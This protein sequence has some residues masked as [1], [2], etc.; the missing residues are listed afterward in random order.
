M[1]SESQKM[2]KQID[3]LKSLSTQNDEF[4]RKLNIVCG[5]SIAPL[6]RVKIANHVDDVLD[7]E[8]SDKTDI[9]MVCGFWEGLIF[10]CSRR[11]RDGFPIAE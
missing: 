10:P 8:Q 6:S 4:Q 2:N 9:G 11:N 1:F 7:L 3:Y 5:T